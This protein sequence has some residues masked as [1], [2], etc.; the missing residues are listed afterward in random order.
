MLCPMTR[1]SC[2]SATDNSSALRSKRI[3]SRVVSAAARRIFT[4]DGMGE[5]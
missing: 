5:F 3:R 4:I 2:N 1:I